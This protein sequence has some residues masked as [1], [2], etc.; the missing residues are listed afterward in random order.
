MS[1]TPAMNLPCELT[2]PEAVRISVSMRSFSTGARG[3]TTV[4]SSSAVA[5]RQV[6]FVWAPSEEVASIEQ[7]R[8]TDS[9]MES[10]LISGEQDRAEWQQSRHLCDRSRQVC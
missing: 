4:L 8:I 9:F 1:T 10:S 2:M 7:R 6:G 5:V 3:G